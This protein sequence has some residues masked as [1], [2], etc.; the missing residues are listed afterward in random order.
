[1]RSLFGVS[2]LPLFLVYS[3]SGC[4]SA[5]DPQDE[6][7]G[8]VATSGSM[9]VTGDTAVDGSYTYFGISADLRRC[10]SPLCGGW[11]LW[12]VNQST[13]VCHDGSRAASCY[14]PVLDW[15][16]ANLSAVQQARLLD[17]S[18]REAGSG[19]VYAIV[20]GRFARTNATSQPRTGRFVITEAWVGETT[21]VPEGVFVRMFDNGVRCFAAPCPSVTEKTL[22]MARS[23]DVAYV[24]FTPA[25]LTE[26]QIAGCLAD[27]STPG[28]I[29]MVGDR[30]TVIE[31]GVTA[32]GRTATAAYDRLSDAP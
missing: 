20:R 9:D 15:T 16:E 32:M 23:V 30:Y 11:F 19:E 1:M 29:L 14:A 22:N 6:I 18:S 3:P 4:A 13:T 21:A 31:N 27:M 17:A 10:P 2:V 8:E 25:G 7:A 26:P 28:G 12:R 5:A 24:D